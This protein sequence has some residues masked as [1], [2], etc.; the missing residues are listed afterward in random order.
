MELLIREGDY[1]PDGLGGFVRRRGA[2]EVLQR[3]LFRLTARRGGLPF[4]PQ[5]GS[6]LHLVLREKPVARQALAQRY[7]AEA[8]EQER[9]VQVT[10][11]SLTQDGGRGTLTV[12][13][14]WQGESL[15]VQARLWEGE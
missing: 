7:V 3:V 2:E 5:L 8:L 10:G 9:D 15:S 13:L 14:N 11:V 12:R 6:R 4:L 1:V